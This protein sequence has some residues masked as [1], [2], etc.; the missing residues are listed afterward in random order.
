MPTTEDTKQVK[1]IPYATWY[2]QCSHDANSMC[3]KKRYNATCWMERED[4]L[5]PPEKQMKSPG[6]QA[7][8]HPGN[9]VHQLQGRAIAFIVLRQLLQGLQEWNDT[10]GYALPD[11]A[12][13]VTPEFERIQAGIKSETRTPCLKLNVPNR[14]C[15]IP[16]HARSEYTPRFHPAKSSI[17]SII[18]AGVKIPEAEPNLYDPPEPFNPRFFDPQED[19][20]SILEN[21]VGFTPNQSRRA[22]AERNALPT[23]FSPKKVTSNLE[24]GQ[25]W[26]LDTKSNPDACDGTMDSFCGRSKKENCLL[27]GHNGMCFAH[28]LATN[29][30]R[31]LLT[32]L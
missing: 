2:M 28:P 7:K 18:K 26:H 30:F 21:G 12:W 17:R 20:L 4:G 5:E 31:Y 29:N 8:W 14:T 3:Q 23:I 16:Q 25:G 19:I 11:E 1:S 6:G 27:N 15:D 32:L 10:P 13:H 9:R 24:P 22:A